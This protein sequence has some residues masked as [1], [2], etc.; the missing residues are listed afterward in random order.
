MFKVSK[1]KHTYDV[2]L[3][4]INLIIGLII[5]FENIPRLV[6]VFLLLTYKHCEIQTSN[7]IL[8]DNYF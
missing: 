7:E 5:N 8:N 4:I 2:S 6:L 1:H 3:V